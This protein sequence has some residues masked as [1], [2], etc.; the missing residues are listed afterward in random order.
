MLYTLISLSI[1][2]LPVTTFIFHTLISKLMSRRGSNVLD[3]SLHFKHWTE[4]KKIQ[5]ITNF[6]YSNKFLCPHKI[7]FLVEVPYIPY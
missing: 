1:H 7:I 6:T 3:L 4:I 2:Y 5:S